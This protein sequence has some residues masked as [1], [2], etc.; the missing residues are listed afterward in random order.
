MRKNMK[1]AFARL[2]VLFRLPQRIMEW[3]GACYPMLLWEGESSTT[4]QG[5][6]K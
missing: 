6:N 5:N 1:R 3:N 2:K 4:L